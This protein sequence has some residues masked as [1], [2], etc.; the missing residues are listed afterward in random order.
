MNGARRRHN[1]QFEA[2][3]DATR[4]SATRPAIELA[5][6][7]GARLVWQ[8]SGVAA[9]LGHDLFERSNLSAIKLERVEL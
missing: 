3:R 2:Q 6:N 7:R 4:R 1:V 8:V 9:Q 5:A